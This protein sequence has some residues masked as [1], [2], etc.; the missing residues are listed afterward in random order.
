MINYLLK[1]SDW[2]HGN[3]KIRKLLYNDDNNNVQVVCNK[4]FGVDK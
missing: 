3:F 4:Y 2:Q 1:V